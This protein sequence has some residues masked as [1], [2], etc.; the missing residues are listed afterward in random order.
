MSLIPYRFLVRVKYSCPHV[1]SMPDDDAEC[2]IDLPESARLDAFADIDAAPKFADVR[3]AWNQAGLGL[4][5][6]VRGKENPPIGD[7]DRLRQSDGLTL[8]IDT[9]SDRSGHR[10]T[11]TCHQ[12]HFLPA[13]GGTNE[14][15]RCLPR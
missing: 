4:Q 5:V 11:R 1:A 7:P 15:N 8:W 3:L 9:R 13:G 6:E 12:F 2:L 14:M 10:A